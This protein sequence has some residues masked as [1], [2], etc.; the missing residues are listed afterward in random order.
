LLFLSIFS[1]RLSIPYLLEIAGR[2]HPLILHFPIGLIFIT[3]VIYFFRRKF[4]PEPV[5]VISLLMHFSALFAVISALLGIF[6]SGE[7]GYDESLVY[8]HKWTG[9]AVSI[10]S[11]FIAFFYSTGKSSPVIPFMMILILPVLIL[12]SHFGASITHGEGY[13][14]PE[15]E[16]K[17]TVKTITDSTSIFDAVIEP[18][19][20]TKCYSCHNEKKAK[21]ELIM[22]SLEKLLSGGK[23]G[24]IWVPGDP[25][26]SH[27]IQR[28]SLEENDKKHMPPRGK[29]QL[30]DMEIILL[31]EWIKNGANTGIRFSDLL[32]AD[33]FRI[34]AS[35]FIPRKE[36]VNTYS[37]PAASPAI[38]EKL[39]S[40]YR[41][42]RAL[43]NG[44][45]ALRVDFFIREGFS[46]SMLKEL[47]KIG[48]QIVELNL[49]NMPVTDAEMVI[50]ST[51][52]NLAFLNLNGTSVKGSNIDVLQQCK[53]LSV[54]SLAG[55][56]VQTESLQLLGGMKHIKKVF[57]WNT[58]TSAADIKEMSDNF[59][60]IQWDNGFIP[61][62]AERLQL[63]PPLLKNDDQ[64]VL[65][66]TD[67]IAFKHPMPGVTIRYTIDGND[68]DSNLS[69]IYGKTFFTDKTI[70]LK[71]IAVRPGWNTSTVTS[72]TL[73]A[74]G[75]SPSFSRLLN[76][77]DRQYTANGIQTL[78]DGQKGETS[79]LKSS[80]LGYREIPFD[81]KFYFEN[82]ISIHEVV[83]ST[84]KNIGAFVMPPQK[85]EI[86]GGKDTVNLTLIKTIIPRQPTAF[87]PEDI[88]AYKT[89][90][91]GKYS[92]IR[93]VVY[94]VKK[95]PLWHGGKGEKAWIF[96]DEVFFN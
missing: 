61:D 40:P 48:P 8:S 20:Y 38:I 23:N 51:F 49:S 91:N 28:L 83:I 22:T 33:S 50:I 57:C 92:C 87:E 77:A 89:E 86:W 42:I 37:F 93:M 56:R 62:A 67:S 36:N 81:A 52:K 79:N 19:L 69:T 59:K 35:S 96:L 15:R 44:S 95:L 41:S 17:R 24:E 66:K 18:V 94:P 25:L 58:A 60:H 80:W 27:I 85:I 73:F 63:T 14:L 84:A 11:A 3:V 53:K 47:E 82:G 16:E 26:N 55:T 45:P 71:A 1:D 65:G 90:V 9:V 12:G 31:S 30:T 2:F 7:G 78:L 10:I 74:R 6:L 75:N 29:P 32:P 21:G 76:L 13:L 46:S 68:P 54:V 4:V 39:Q 5:E 64:R 70:Q 34:F 88:V 72:V 43:S